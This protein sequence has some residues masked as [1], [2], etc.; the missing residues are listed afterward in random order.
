MSEDEIKYLDKPKLKNPVLIEGLPGIGNVGRVSAGYM[1]SQLKAKKFAELY[2]HNFLP[3]VVMQKNGVARMLKAEF[4]YYHGK[5]NDLIFVV[6]DSQSITPHG[7]YDLCNSILDLAEKFNVKEIITL[8]GLGVDSIKGVPKIV[9]AVNSEKL[10]KKFK[11][12]GIIFDGSLVGTI[13]GVSGLLIGLAQ[14]RGIDAICLMAETAGFP[15]V[16]TD[17]IAAEAMLNMLTRILDIKI[18]MTRLEKEVNELEEKIKKT[19]EFHKKML[20]KLQAESKEHVGY[21]G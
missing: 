3:L 18:D 13:I 21:I 8:G 19:E 12:F 14:V 11:P 17:P 10:L 9:G 6:G 20:S 16:I 1:I 15:I 7:Y 4:Y 2:S 5:K